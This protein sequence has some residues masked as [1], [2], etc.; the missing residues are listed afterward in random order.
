MKKI[1]VEAI[2]DMLLSYCPRKYSD[3]E[4]LSIIT[5]YEWELENVPPEKLKIGWEKAVSAHDGFMMPPGKFKELCL[6]EGG[7]KSLEDDGAQAWS[8]VIKNL[9]SSIAPIFK[10]T[11]I[12]ETVNKMGGW[13]GFCR[14]ITEQNQDFKR[15]DFIS[16]YVMCRN[17]KQ[18][19]SPLP[20]RIAEFFQDGENRPD[21]RFIGFEDPAEQKTALRLAIEKRRTAR[22]IAGLLAG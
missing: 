11:S 8:L 2:V 19:F 17:Q 10:D 22:K 21:Y 1:S 18:E 5:G 7:S 6:T 15:R 3:K 16:L 12:A 20:D 9:N 4:R 14:S 13:I